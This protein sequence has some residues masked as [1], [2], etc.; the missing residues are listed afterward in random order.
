[1]GIA[2]PMQVRSARAAPP[3]PEV[4]DTGQHTIMST[5]RSPARGACSM[6]APPIAALLTVHRLP[7]VQAG[8]L[9]F[10]L[11]PGRYHLLFIAGDPV[12][13]PEAL[14]VAVVLPELLR[15]FRGRFGAALVAPESEHELHARYGCTRWPALVLLRGDAYVGSIERMRDW[16]DYKLEL[17]RLLAAPPQRAP[18]VGIPVAAEPADPHHIA[19]GCH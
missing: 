11:E 1:M 4:G 3:V 18:G 17:E 6:T 14:D 16:D 5:K 10:F 8:D 13:Y 19:G 12:K 2:V 15:T 7:L 9:G